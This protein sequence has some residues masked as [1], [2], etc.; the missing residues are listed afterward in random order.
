MDI[1]DLLL[2]QLLLQSATRFI[3]NYVRYHKVRTILQIA[4]AHLYVATGVKCST[5]EQISVKAW[6]S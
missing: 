3:T 2:R 5:F 6:L 4:K 1:L